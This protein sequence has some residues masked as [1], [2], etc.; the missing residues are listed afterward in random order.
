VVSVVEALVIILFSV[1]VVR[2]GYTGN[3][4]GSMYKLMKTLFCLWRLHEFSNW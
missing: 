1:L 4:V 3:V 2:N